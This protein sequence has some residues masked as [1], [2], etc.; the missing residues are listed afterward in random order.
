TDLTLAVDS[1]RGD[2]LALSGTGRYRAQDFSLEGRVDPPAALRDGAYRLELRA[3][4][5]ATRATLAGAVQLPLHLREFTVE[6]GLE[7]PSLEALQALPD[8]SFPDTPPDA[9]HGTLARVGETWRYRDFEGTVGDSDM[10]GRVTVDLSGERPHLEA[11]LKSDLLDF[12]DLGPVIGGAPGTGP[13]ETATPAQAALAAERAREGRLLPAREFD[14]AALRAM[15]ANVSL[16]AA[17]VVTRKAPVS[18]MSVG[19]ELRDGVLRLDPLSFATGGGR[20]TGEVVLDASGDPDLTEAALRVRGLELPELF[21]DSRL[22]QRS[23]GTIAA[24]VELAGHGN[25]V[26][27]MLATADGHAAAAMGRGRVSNLVLE[28]AGLDIAEALAFL[29]TEDR[30]APV[31]CAFADFAIE[32]GRMRARALV[33]DTTDT[34]VH[35]EGSIDLAAER[36][37]LVLHPCPRDASIAALRVPLAVSGSLR[38]PDI[39]PKGGRLAL[40]ALAGAALYAVAPPAALLALVE[41]GPGESTDCG[42]ATALRTAGAEPDVAQPAPPHGT[43]P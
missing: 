18:A 25:S 2:G 16:D 37:D 8:L 11:K 14:L 41:T 19:L 38:D 21:P 13:D 36:L 31:R 26:A 12:D 22:G 33:F 43:S 29:L 17:Q 23:L 42:R 1:T 5:G 28:L 6:L 39:A 9:I 27:A 7:G 3:R 32:D 15:D 4:A 20:L 40:R 30:T 34:I 10:G 24:D 35:G